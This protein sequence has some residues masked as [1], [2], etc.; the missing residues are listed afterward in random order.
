[1]HFEE[2]L[3]TGSELREALHVLFQ[4]RCVAK[5]P[6]EEH[7]VVHQFERT[8]GVVLERGM[9]PEECLGQDALS[10][11]PTLAL[12][13][14]QPFEQAVSGRFVL[15]GNNQVGFQLVITVPQAQY[16]GSGTINGA[17]NYG[18]FVTALDG[19]QPG[20]GGVDKFRIQI[21]DKSRG[22][23]IV[24][25]TQPGA[26]QTAAP[27]TVLGGGSIAIHS[28]GNSPLPPGGPGNSGT[29]KEPITARLLDGLFA[30]QVQTERSLEAPQAP[31]LQARFPARSSPKMRT[32]DHTDS[33]DEE[34]YSRGS[35]SV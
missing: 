13:I 14:P 9:L 17:G 7:F 10:L 21:W 15:D 31:Q 27:T 16:Q 4:L 33:T 6:P 1:M 35:L 20:G 11:F 24:Y 22:N 3:E 18:F 32:T 25:D 30:L 26:A 29:N 2:P 12:F 5:L 23:A 8:L 34:E 28:N 19:K